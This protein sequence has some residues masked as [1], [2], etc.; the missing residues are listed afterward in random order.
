MAKLSREAILDAAVR[1]VDE[2]GIAKLS[3]RKL[4]AE[5]GVEAMT[6]YYY[7]PNKEA[8]LDGLVDHVTSSVDLVARGGEQWPD[9]LRRIAVSLRAALLAHPGVLPLVSTRPVL[10]GSSLDAVEG[11]LSVLYATGFTARQALDALNII[12]TFT[13]GHTLA[14]AGR[15][16]GHEDADPDLDAFVSELDGARHPLFAAAV[17]SGGGTNHAERFALA[18]DMLI[19]GIGAG[20]ATGTGHGRATNAERAVSRARRP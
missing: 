10:S 3:M 18:I 16:P 11:A 5:L 8:L 9:L 17:R 6:L 14:E 1:F 7:L 12:G 20:R 19:T 4:G 13:V 15:T 2:H